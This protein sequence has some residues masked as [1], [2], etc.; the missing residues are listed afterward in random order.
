M[1]HA[2]W[3]VCP[4]HQGTEM[5]CKEARSVL[6]WTLCPINGEE[7]STPPPSPSGYTPKGLGSSRSRHSLRLLPSPPSIHTLD[8]ATLDGT[9]LLS[10]FS[11]TLYLVFPWYGV[12]SPRDGVGASL[13]CRVGVVQP[14]TATTKRR[15]A[16]HA[17]CIDPARCLSCHRGRRTHGRCCWRHVVRMARRQRRMRRL[18]GV[19]GTCAGSFTPCHRQ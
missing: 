14:T 15:K 11:S 9:C 8:H 17:A 3:K 13:F 12:V 4:S 16:H 10:S 1:A 7:R 18:K 2:S 6:G 5:R 19:P